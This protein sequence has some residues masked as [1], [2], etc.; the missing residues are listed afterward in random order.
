MKY[1]V[2]KILL[3]LAEKN[4]SFVFLFPILQIPQITPIQTYLGFRGMDF[5][6]TLVCL[7]H[8]S[9]KDFEKK[10]E[11]VR[12]NKYFDFEVS[13]DD[14]YKYA[15]FNFT[16]MPDLYK[17]VLKGKYSTIDGNA[18]RVL[19]FSND[20]LINFGLFPEQF[21]DEYSLQLE[22]PI[23]AIKAGIEL[24]GPPDSENE[25]I[26]VNQNLKIQLADYL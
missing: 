25:F 3:K 24:I 26:A 8:P 7:M 1:N 16:S 15:V 18:R 22:Y 5:G 4:K 23:E 2:E 20:P 19:T 21:Y 9:Q 13:G 11:I 6:N 10:L 14:E 12:K 17:K